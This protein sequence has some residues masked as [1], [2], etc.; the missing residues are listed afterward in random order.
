M[1]FLPYSPTTS[2]SLSLLSTKLAFQGLRMILTSEGYL[3]LTS[4][5]HTAPMQ[6]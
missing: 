4:V 2:L 6:S 3:P 5:A 1:I